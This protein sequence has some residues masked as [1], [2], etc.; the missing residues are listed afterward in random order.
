MPSPETARAFC[1]K[2]ACEWA[3]R[4]PEHA[5]NICVA[6][7]WYCHGEEVKALLDRSEWKEAI[8]AEANGKSL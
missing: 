5:D 1:A 8:T 2:T 3:Q 6:Q 4:F 7:I